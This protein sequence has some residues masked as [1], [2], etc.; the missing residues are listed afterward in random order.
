MKRFRNLTLAQLAVFEQ[1]AAGN[2]K[3]HHPSTLEALV[4]KI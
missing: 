3:G 4:E 1:I 2:D